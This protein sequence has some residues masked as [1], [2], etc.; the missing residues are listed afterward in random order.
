M[1]LM[2][3]QE[4][5]KIWNVLWSETTDRSKGSFKRALWY[6]GKNS[7]K[8]GMDK[9]AR[10]ELRNAPR[11][12]ITFRVGKIPAIG[13]IAAKVAD[14]AAGAAKSIYSKYVKPKVK[15]AP[16]GTEASRKVAKRAVKDLKEGD[17]IKVIDRNMVKM[18]DA[19]N[20]ASQKLSDYNRAANGSDEVRKEKAEAAI[21][22][23][24][25]VW[26][27]ED[28]IINLASRVQAMMDDLNRGLAELHDNTGKSCQ[29]LYDD[30]CRS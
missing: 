2:T 28:K 19:R 9:G 20:K 6:G 10:K 4:L 22:A 24:F 30:L 1:A 14:P 21:R 27:Y 16:T 7:S 11:K 18:K 15:K 25:E 3:E 13:E 8:I 23:L 17:V 26:Y 5:D 12:L 29:D